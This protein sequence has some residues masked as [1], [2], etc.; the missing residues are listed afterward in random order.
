M[1][2]IMRRNYLKSDRSSLGGRIIGDFNFF[3]IFYLCSKY[4]LYKI[5]ILIYY[6]FQVSTSVCVFYNQQHILIK[7]V[8]MS[9]RVRLPGKPSRTFALCGDLPLTS[10]QALCFSSASVL[11]GASHSSVH[12]SQSQTV[13]FSGQTG[14][15][16]DFPPAQ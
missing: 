16:N 3:F 4:N 15:F 5:F 8:Q 11:P 1:E 10:P 6:V 14:V 7:H 9:S 13:I 12:L 2:N